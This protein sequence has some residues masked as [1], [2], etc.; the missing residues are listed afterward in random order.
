MPNP[1]RAWR[2]LPQPL[3]FLARHAALGFGAAA[4]FV[5]GLLLTDP[6]NA[7]TLL[8]TAADHWWPAALLWGLTG[9]TFAGAQ[10]G[11]AIMQQGAPPPRPPG[12][13]RAP[14]GLVPVPVPVRVR[15]RRR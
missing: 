3:R 10:I 7:G 2:L 14:A 11:I 13:S 9:S 15:A 8:L 5:G 1:I 4:I 12:G 6:G